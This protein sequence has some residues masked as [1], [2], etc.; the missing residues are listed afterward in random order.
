M[1]VLTD[2]RLPIVDWTLC[3][4][5]GTDSRPPRPGRP[6]RPDRRHGQHGA[7][8]LTYQQLSDE[9]AA[10]GISLAVT[11]LADNTRLSGSC[12]TDELDRGFARTRDVLLTPTFPAEE[13]DKVKAQAVAGVTQSLASPATAGSQEM[14]RLLYGDTPLGRSATPA[15]V[16]AVTLDDVKRCYADTYRPD[17]AILTLSGDVSFDRGVALAKQL[18]DGWQ[19]KPLPAVSYDAAVPG[20]GAAPAGDPDRQPRPLGRGRG[21]R[22]HGRPGVRHPRRPASTP[23]PWPT[24]CSARAS[25]PA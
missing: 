4:R 2:H 15:T 5:R 24:R 10:H 18:T 11:A 6:G 22:P 23:G 21:D 17:D 3:M 7:A 19:P 25:S 13:F 8:G 9:L 16:S 14:D 1:V 20:H 12:T